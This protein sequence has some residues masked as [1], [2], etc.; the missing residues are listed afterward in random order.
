MT[1]TETDHPKMPVNQRV[2]LFARHLLAH[3]DA[4]RADLA[5]KFHCRDL[6]VGY[7]LVD[8]ITGETGKTKASRVSLGLKFTDDVTA[9]AI[10]LLGRDPR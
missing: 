4:T 7:C 9:T 8:G 5:A 10:R 3:P 1:T 2:A 6:V